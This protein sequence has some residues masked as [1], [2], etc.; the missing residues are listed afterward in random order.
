MN[1]QDTRSQT[2]RVIIHGQ[3]YPI[4]SQG[5]DSEYIKRVAAYVD[6]IMNRIEEEISVN[7]LSRLAILTALNITDELFSVQN[8][9]ERLGK[10][11]EEKSKL[12]SE[13][14]EKELKEA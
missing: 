2:V 8:E 12:I 14:L 11:F 3:E 5:G 1:G 9:Q 4:K 7:S 10:F 6:E 13:A